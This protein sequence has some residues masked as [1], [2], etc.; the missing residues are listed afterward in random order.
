M[1]YQ[2][3]DAFEYDIRAAISAKMMESGCSYREAVL[4]LNEI[5]KRLAK[6]V[7]ISEKAVD[8]YLMKRGDVN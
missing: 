1:L 2:R 4:E 5:L 7:Q 3:T 6:E 8:A